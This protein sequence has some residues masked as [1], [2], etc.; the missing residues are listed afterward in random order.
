MVVIH[1]RTLLRKMYW[2]PAFQDDDCDRRGHCHCEEQRWE[3]GGNKMIRRRGRPSGA[4]AVRLDTSSPQSGARIL[5]ILSDR[6]VP[7]NIRSY[8]KILLLLY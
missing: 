8:H 5:S 6:I 3:C 1:T 4:A 7:E 2:S